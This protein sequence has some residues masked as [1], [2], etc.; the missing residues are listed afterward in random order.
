MTMNLLTLRQF[1]STT[2][3]YELVYL[4]TNWSPLWGDS[5]LFSNPITKTH[6]GN[7]S[8]DSLSASTL[9]SRR[10]IYPKE[11]LAEVTRPEKVAK[12]SNKPKGPQTKEES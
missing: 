8:E 1:I 4:P 11:R 5:C 2:F 6:N 12:E 3:P 10:R 9:R 7:Q